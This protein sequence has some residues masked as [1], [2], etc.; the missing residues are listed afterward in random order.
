MKK[1]KL[2][3]ISEKVYFYTFLLTVA[4]VF[5]ASIG[6]MVAR[7]AS[8]DSK[9]ELI[10]DNVFKFIKDVIFAFILPISIKI[11]GDYVPAT[12]DLIREIKGIKGFGN[13]NQV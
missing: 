1:E 11:V 9:L 10:P 12:I 13:E 6:T 7:W 2:D 4:L 5:L 8:G 3:S